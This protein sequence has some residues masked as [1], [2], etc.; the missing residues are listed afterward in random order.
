[1][2]EVLP[3]VTDGLKAKSCGLL[4]ENSL[5]SINRDVWDLEMKMMLRIKPQIKC[6]LGKL[7]RLLTNVCE[8]SQVLL[9]HEQ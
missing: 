9:L 6:I 2:R 4:E 5:A 7:Q 8:A 3:A 1:M